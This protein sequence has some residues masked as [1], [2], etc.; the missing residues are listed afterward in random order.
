M[1]GSLLPGAGFA[2]RG[3]TLAGGFTTI[4]LSTPGCASEP[5]GGGRCGLSVA[6]AAADPAKSAKV[7]ATQMDL[8]ES[9]DFAPSN[10]KLTNS[11]NRFIETS[12]TV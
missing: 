7:P 9:I 1:P 5:A 11:P 3:S 10:M 12:S 4:S 8:L 6:C 2:S